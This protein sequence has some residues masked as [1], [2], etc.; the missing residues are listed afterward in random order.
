MRRATVRAVP[1]HLHA[2]LTEMFRHRPGLAAELLC[3]VLGTPLPPYREATLGAAEVVAL[4]PAEHRA[5]AVVQLTGSTGPVCAVVVEIQ[6]HRDED[7]RWT[8]PEYVASVRRRWRCPTLLLVVCADVDTARW[9]AT[10]I[11]LGNTG[12]CL[13]PAVLGPDL[14]PVVT[15]PIAAARTPELAVL[16]ALA[17]ARDEGPHTVLDVLADAL[18]HVEVDHAVEYAWLVLAALPDRARAHLEELMSTQTHEYQSDFTRRLRGEGQAEGRAQG[19]AEGR[20]AMVLRIL[21]HRGLD[22]SPSTRA[23]V[24]GCTDLAQLEAWGDRALTADTVDEIF[25]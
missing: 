3:G 10:P 11:E 17:H 2:T 18:A 20:A 9:A 6:L 24:S 7:K 5:D 15:D 25:D 12:S 8:W 16:S 22:V 23:R 14:V 4:R 13:R 1:S 21:A 19:Q